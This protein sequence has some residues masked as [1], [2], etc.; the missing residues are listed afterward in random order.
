MKYLDV[1]MNAAE[2]PIVEEADRRLAVGCERRLGGAS[3]SA[4]V[5]AAIGSS[6]TVYGSSSR[7]DG[8]RPQAHSIIP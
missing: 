3:I 7:G 2:V 5:G 8:M 4:L 6:L 1:P